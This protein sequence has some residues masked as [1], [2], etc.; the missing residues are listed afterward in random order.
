MSITIKGRTF[1]DRWGIADLRTTTALEEAYRQQAKFDQYIYAY[2]GAHNLFREGKSMMPATLHADFLNKE[3]KLGEPSTQAKETSEAI[4]ILAEQAAQQAQALRA[5]AKE[6]AAKE[7]AE[8]IA[9]AKA[10]AAA[11]K[12]R[13]KEEAEKAKAQAKKDAAVAKVAA[14][15]A[16]LREAETL[17]SDSQAILFAARSLIGAG[18]YTNMSG[19]LTPALVARLDAQRPL[20]AALGLKTLVVGKGTYLIWA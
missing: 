4:A 12:A 20:I 15:K 16:A 8:M 1:Q 2:G 6:A 14:A 3:A 19:E 10:D 13:A 11:A 18:G 17:Y 7:R 5:E 9:K